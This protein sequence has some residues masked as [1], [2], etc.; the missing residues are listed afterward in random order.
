L[1]KLRVLFLAR[2]LDIG[3]TQRQL[4][5]LAVELRKRGHQVSIALFYS[6]GDLERDLLSGGV[7]LH[8][9]NKK[10]R[11]DVLGFGIRLSRLL[12][13]EKPVILYSYLPGPNV[14]AAISK[15]L[16]CRFRLVWG[17]RGSAPDFHFYDRVERLL[18]TVENKLSRYADL[19][20]SNSDAGRND[21]V[22][23]GFLKH[24]TRV[25][26]NGIDTEKFKPDGPGRI[27]LRSEW[28]IE[29]GQKAIGLVGRLDPMKDHPTFLR[30]AAAL[31]ARRQNLRFVCIGG[32]PPKY[33]AILETL[34]VSLGLTGSVVWSD[35]RLDL[36]AVYS[37]LD[38]LV[39]ASAFGEG[40]SN[41]V[42]EAMACGVPAVVTRIGDSAKIVGGEG[43]V[44][45]PGDP[46]G[47]AKGIETL[48]SRIETG[49]YSEAHARIAA[50][51]S[52]IEHNY[53][54][55]KFVSSTQD[56]L[57]ELVGN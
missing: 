28:R 32:G 29:D 46:L 24:R 18:F 34:S 42:G 6:G 38:I 26:P 31:V 47:L 15:I 36:P 17:V 21:A 52:R 14:I 16:G 48:L 44:V 57:C 41:V 50:N 4:A 37:A 53:S 49:D 43:E 27:R 10:G 35:T 12:K 23:R 45:D 19:I 11:W 22:K 3:G 5:T 40:L 13:T 33:R 30:A 20:V 56:T 7:T 1:T 39:S 25:I 2:A 55:R 9:L 54:M 51:R 8:Q